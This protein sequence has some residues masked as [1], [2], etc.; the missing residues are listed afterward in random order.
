MNSLIN[1]LFQKTKT[2]S[3]QSTDEEP[4]ESFNFLQYFYSKGTPSKK[5]DALKMSID[6]INYNT[7]ENESQYQLLKAYLDIE[8]FLINEDSKY[9]ENIEYLR[10]ELKEN[11]PDITS[12]LPFKILYSK[13]SI[14]EIKLALLLT[15]FLYDKTSNHCG[16]VSIL[17][18]EFTVYKEIETNKLKGNMAYYLDSKRVIR[19][20]IKKLSKQIEE[21]CGAKDIIAPQIEWCK[22]FVSMYKSIKSSNKMDFYFPEKNIETLKNIYTQTKS[23]TNLIHIEQQDIPQADVSIYT[24]ALEN[25]LDQAIIFDPSGK[26]LFANDKARHF[27]NLHNVVLSS[28]NIYRLLPGTI[29]NSLKEDV[30]D[31]EHKRPNIV[32]GKRI[33]ID[34]KKKD[35]T[36]QHYEITTTN[37]FT[38]NG[39]TYSLFIKDITRGKDK[40]NTMSKEMEHVQ[41][42]AKAKSTFLSNMSHEIRTPLNVILGLS[43]IIK[44]GENQDKELFKKNIEGIDFSAKN[45]LSIVNDILDFSKIEAGKLSI[46]SYDYNLKKVITS[47]TDGFRTKS[48]E[49]GVSL[50]TDIDSKI[51]DIVIGDQYRLNQILTNLIGNAIKFTNEGEIKVIVTHKSN[52]DGEQKIHFE[53]KDTGIGIPED[54][55]DNIFNSFYQVEGTESSK[56]TGTGLGLAIT[57]ELIHL[58]D[59][60]LSATSKKGKGSS[61]YFTLPLVKSKLKSINDIVDVTTTRNDEELE[62]LRVLVAEDN[63]MNQ[64]YIKQLLNRLKVEVDIAE[65]GQEAIDLFFSKGNG[66]YNLILM[67]MHMPILGGVDAIKQI[68]KSQKQK[69]GSKKVPIVICSADVFPESRKNAIKAG[70]DFYL[71]KPVDEDALKEVLFWLISD[72][73]QGLET[74]TSQGEETRNNTVAIDK[75]Q[76]T[77]DNDEEFIITLLEI[78]IQDTPDDYKSLCACVE[79]EFYPRAAELAHKMKSSFMNLGMTHQGHFLQQIEKHINTKEGREL[80]I[81]HFEQFKSIYTKSLLDVNILLIELK[82]K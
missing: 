32:L 57:K 53:V 26:L 82:R 35:G 45:L 62:G 16:Y 47:L 52:I 51:P 39:D 30:E 44:K 65:N 60:E 5:L 66:Y 8:Q 34:L 55:L 56:S 75:L 77:F 15:K 42:A 13:G 31:I 76:E 43:D 14:Q 19:K 50:Y 67:D 40:F 24:S 2:S 46:Q 20:Y 6:S 11:Y 7:D 48:N 1:K 29:A 25:M 41:R 12:L 49:K 4:K 3:I 18:P 61:F 73:K 17:A 54:K 36:K 72:D 37:N 10:T 9:K 58:Q 63:T 27:F 22:E 74:M 28:K 59:G 81:K 38:E 21:S 69:R 23:E 79:R 68:R 33:E 71:T 70:I 78:F 80:G 64:F